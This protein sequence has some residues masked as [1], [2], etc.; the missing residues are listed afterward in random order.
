M[1]RSTLVASLVSAAL[2]AGGVAR[3]EEPQETRCP[4][5]FGASGALGESSAADRLHYIQRTAHEDAASARLWSWG[6]SAATVGVAAAQFTWGAI[7]ADS[8]SVDHY[9][10]GGPILIIPATTLIF[11][12]DVL[13]DEREIDALAG[14]AAPSLCG[15]L[16]RAEALFLRDAEDEDSRHDF[17][18]HALPLLGTA[19]GALALGFGY[20]H[21]SAAALNG[22]A[23]L[24]T[25]ELHIWTAP[26]RLSRNYDRYRAGDLS[27][28]PSS[29]E[30][31]E[32][33]VLPTV[34]SDGFGLSLGGSF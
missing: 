19:A 8:N 27:A 25:N 22:A 18:A 7:L 1:N 16:S 4:V 17:L 24:V 28:E 10:A 32:L 5:P 26:T 11:P 15:R 12:L 2:L 31:V 3:A 9:M 20:Q 21:W 30:R 34:G 13:S 6:W 33:T 14:G 23:G 29:V